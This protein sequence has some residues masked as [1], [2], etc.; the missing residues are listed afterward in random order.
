MKRW[1]FPLIL[2]LLLTGCG[3]RGTEPSTDPST[4]APAAPS[5]SQTVP[6]AESTEPHT[7]PTTEPTEPSPP[8]TTVDDGQPMN[9]MELYKEYDAVTG[10]GD[11]ILLF[12]G[13][14]L[15]LWN[16]GAENPSVVIRIAGLPLPGGGQLQV[17][18]ENIVYFD[19]TAKAVVYLDNELEE[20]KR[21]S[22][23]EEILGRPWLAADG[24]KLYFCCPE[25]LRVWDLE[26]GICRNLK[27]QAGNWLGI[28]GSLLEGTALRCQ[29]QEDDGTVR[30]L[31]VSAENGQTL[32]EGEILNSITGNGSMYCCV[33]GEEW[34]FGTAGDRPQTLMLTEAV[35][36]PEIQAAVN[37]LS[38]KGETILHLIDLT[39]GRCVATQVMMAESI[40]E[41]MAF[42]GYIWFFE[43][44]QLW[45]WDPA[46]S[47]VEQ[48]WSY[49][50]YRYTYDDP[51]VEGLAAL[52]AR[53][54]ALAQQ[55]GI[56]VL[57]WQNV[58]SAEPAGYTFGIEYRTDVYERAI[59][60]LEAAFA[61][62]PEQMLSRAAD[63]ATDGTLHIVL[64]S[65]IATPSDTAYSTVTG[66]EY[67]LD[68]KVYIVLEMGDHMESAFY[69]TLYHV[70]DPLVL[71]NSIAYYKWN[72][73]NPKG[74][75]Y[76]NDYLANLSRDG[77][78]YLEGTRY[79]ID[80]F[81]MSYAV[82]DR[83]RI[84]EYAMMAD[85]G[86][87]FNSEPMQS[88]LKMLCQGL[89]EVFGLTG[90][91]YPWEQYLK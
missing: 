46:L 84:F 16:F 1:I 44:G 24:N 69:H 4:T 30:T 43:N 85:N 76:D 53:A 57:M 28:T 87:Y 42:N 62:L 91:S 5:E 47:A 55:Y 78:Q 21:L 45:R 13:V 11:Q 80:T 60:A 26:T 20:L 14:E 51:D 37:V 65:G 18:E 89:R 31:L 71:S 10:F 75:Q 79:F 39:T 36:L 22:L 54:D 68:G 32:Y 35:P 58:A 41:L 7:A 61:K 8:E 50:S 90:D 81:S 15:S 72:D 88:K 27:I 74:F 19:S 83:A 67:L 48:D 66:M 86:A 23:E 38:S 52:Q 17:T 59:T 77:S 2:A 70:I 40:G 56:Q 49:T 63:W 3:V 64:A 29:L 73:L 25:G 6:T 34:I 9:A 12:S 33:T 82:E